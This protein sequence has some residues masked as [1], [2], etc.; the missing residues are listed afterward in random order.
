MLLP[1]SGRGCSAL[2]AHALE[3]RARARAAPR[4]RAVVDRA[5]VRNRAACMA[6]HPRLLGHVLEHLL[7]DG[8][9]LV[10]LA[11]VTHSG[12]V[13]RSTS[14]P[15]SESKT[16]VLAQRASAGAGF[17]DGASFEPRSRPSAARLDARSAC[18]PRCRSSLS[19]QVRAG[20][21]AR[22]RPA[23]PRRRSSSTAR[24]AAQASG[25]PPNVL[26][27]VPGGSACA[28]RSVTAIA[29]SGKP[30]AMPLASATRVGHDAAVLAAEE[31]PGAAVA[32][33]APRRSISSAP[34]SSH[35]SRAPR[36]YSSA[37][38]DARRLRPAPARA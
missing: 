13:K 25:L 15:A 33:S 17:T 12:G 30:D 11:T 27:C 8:D 37:A 5:S 35:S 18:A 34:R 26:A 7:D 24:P 4:A 28:R 16:P 3:A 32:R 29:P 2:A 38:D 19:P 20:R 31:A 14:P 1:A 10:D 36:R 6:S 9:A 22:S 21:V 23:S